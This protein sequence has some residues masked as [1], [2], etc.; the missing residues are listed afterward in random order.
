MDGGI[1]E[2]FQKVGGNDFVFNRTVQYLWRPNIYDYTVLY[3]VTRPLENP[4][5]QH[6][7]HHQPLL[8]QPLHQALAI[9]QLVGFCCGE[10]FAVVLFSSGVLGRVLS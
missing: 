1:F 5:D 7:H 2:T 6:M 4:R 9:C 3:I 10:H 8:L